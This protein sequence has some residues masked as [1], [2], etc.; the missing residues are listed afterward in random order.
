MT[1]TQSSQF[2]K[3][4]EAMEAAVLRRVEAAK[5]EIVIEKAPDLTDDMRSTAGRELAFARLARD[6]ALLRSIRGGLDRMRKGTF[7]VCLN[8]EESISHKRLAAIPWARLCISC[9]EETDR[10][11]G[12]ISSG[13]PLRSFLPAQDEAEDQVLRRVV[14]DWK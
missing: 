12:R 13:D 5:R 14:H 10:N 1:K 4:L 6:S 9:Q 2:R 3:T 11:S 8:C 7:G